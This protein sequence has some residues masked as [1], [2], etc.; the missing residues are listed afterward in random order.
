M[1]I[2]CTA[3]ALLCLL[4][5][6][7][8][9]AAELPPIRAVQVGPNREIRVNGRPFLPIMLFCQSDER[10]EDG[11]SIAANT[12]A[13]NCGDL[14]KAEWLD[15]LAD[16]GLYG[17]VH[18]DEDCIG[19]PNLLGWIH[20]DEPDNR[21]RVIDAQVG[22]A[23]NMNLNPDTPLERLVD[24]QTNSW[25][26]FDPIAPSEVT[27][28]LDAPATVQSVGVY[29]TIS[30]E[31]PVAK[32]VVFLADGRQ[33]LEA[34]LAKRSG[35]Q[36]F[37]LPS[38]VTFTRL[39]FRIVSAYE[40]GGSWGSVGEIQA[41]DRDGENVLLSEPRTVPK[42][43]PEDIAPYYR[44]I[45]EN[46]PSRPV[47]LTLCPLFME[48][49]TT[50]G[51]ELKARIYPAYIELC[52]VAGTDYYPIFGENYPSRLDKVARCV[53]QLVD[54]AGPRPVFIWLET[55]TGSR[56]I[57]P[58]VQVP[59]KP[60]HTRAEVWMALIR[61]ATAIGYFTHKWRDPDGTDHYMQFA[62]EGEMVEELKRL[63]QRLTRL[64][65]A[66][67]ASP[68]EIEVGMTMS[69][70]LPCH[71]KTTRHEESLYVFA[72]N[73][74]VDDNQAGLRQGEDISPRGGTATFR[75]EGLKEGT[76]IEVVD[77]ERSITAGDGTFADEFGP[78]AVHVY[79]I[80]L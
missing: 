38:P 72:Q 15:K 20:N 46:D 45:K 56:W 70:R 26:V 40:G 68:S 39:T 35:Q 53:E 23:D 37:A 43:M 36:K 80:P 12:F 16:A 7:S 50:Y 48:S 79:R 52:D 64:A 71:F 4:I 19:R 14:S 31:M 1:K 55:N 2:T 17:I 74:H 8:A 60:M 13:S 44:T 54:L 21:R 24:G 76:R 33:V 63:N 49:D 67:L 57:T 30:G 3:L 69:D 51:P 47:F 61:G 5:V 41:F 11:L 28:T 32:D 58:S 25:T 10:I 27:V 75:V 78:L 73:I 65:P 42:S 9:V 18:W 62:P 66:L 77:E 29:L 22:A 59:L 6:G 34:T